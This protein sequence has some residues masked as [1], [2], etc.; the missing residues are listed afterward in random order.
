MKKINN[1]LLAGCVS[2]S[3][4]RFFVAFAKP[5]LAAP[6]KHVLLVYDSLN[7]AREKK[8]NDVD[9]LQRVLT[10]FW[11]KFRVWRYQIMY[12]ANC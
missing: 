9:A 2:Y 7:I 4:F 1:I 10:S 12:L 5:A 6:S 8:K 11:S 3:F